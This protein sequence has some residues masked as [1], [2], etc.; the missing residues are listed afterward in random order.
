MST[1]AQVKII[2]NE[3]SDQPIYLYQHYDG[4]DLFG[5]VIDA[6]QRDSDRINDFEYLNRIIFSEM[7]KD[8]LM[9]T[10]GYGISNDEH[11]DLDYLIVVDMANKRVSCTTAYED[12]LYDYTFDYVLTTP[13][14]E[15]RAS[16]E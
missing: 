1:R 4:Y 6:L 13:R 10:T 11:D 3:K 2:S 8:N 12:R 16:C 5:I 14:D 9:D 15:I 7:I